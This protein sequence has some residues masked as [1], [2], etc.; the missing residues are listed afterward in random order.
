M[1]PVKS[2]KVDDRLTKL[3]WA[4][5]ES[6]SFQK[7]IELLKYL[8]NGTESQ[9]V[10]SEAAICITCWMV[11][12]KN[13]MASHNKMRH[14]VT[15]TFSK[16]QEASKDTYQ[17][18]CKDKNIIRFP[19]QGAQRSI[20]PLLNLGR[21]LKHILTTH[22][23]MFKNGTIDYGSE[24]KTGKG[25][26]AFNSVYDREEQIQNETAN[27]VNKP[28]VK[29]EIKKLTSSQEKQQ[30][31][32]IQNQNGTPQ[33]N[34]TAVSSRKRKRNEPATLINN[35]Q[36]QLT[37]AFQ[38]NLLPQ[39]K[40]KLVIAPSPQEFKKARATINPLPHI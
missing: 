3:V 30:Q 22:C 21:H 18:L 2:E 27:T 4:R 5:T 7:M 35:Q 16:M 26:F 23:P 28:N 29:K 36:Q 12:S 11:M 19:K 25:V 20:Y 40:A 37:S 10:K 32:Q 38:S 33:L 9:I 14:E 24:V 31:T 1:Q 34:N 6:K 13:D 39:K 17:K 8:K 15:G